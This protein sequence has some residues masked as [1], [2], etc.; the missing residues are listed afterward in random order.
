MLGRFQLGTMQG[1]LVPKLNGRYQ[2][3]PKGYW[4]DEFNAAAEFELELI[5]FILDYEDADINPL[6]NDIPAICSA[7]AETGV[8]VESV[9]ADYFMVAPLQRVPR[10]ITVLEKLID[11]SVQLGVRDIVIPCVDQSS[12]VDGS[13]TIAFVNVIQSLAEKANAKEVNLSL[14]TD[15][16]PRPFAEL[17]DR[18]GSK[19]VTVNYDMG[20]SASLGYD[21]V[22]E[23]LAYGDRITDIHIKDRIHGGG[24][25]VLGEGH[26]DFDRVFKQINESSYSGPLI[27]QA[28]RDDEG[29]VIFEKQKTWL[30]DNYGEL[31][32]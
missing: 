2:A 30:E 12:L 16:A 17:L 21:P 14:E 32:Q 15:L 6:L 4:R 11:A 29:R 20:N 18:I 25:V 27:M 13:D 7:I 3:H 8:G 26:C 9:C 22:E 10:S 1:R 31:L 23:F 28:Y 24:P 19:S 5:E